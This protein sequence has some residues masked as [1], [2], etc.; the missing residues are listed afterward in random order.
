MPISG[1]EYLVGHRQETRSGPRHEYF[2]IFDDLAIG[3][4]DGDN[5]R[6]GKEAHGGGHPRGSLVGTPAA[7]AHATVRWLL[8]RANS[9]L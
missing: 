8:E 2:L 3:I 5:G 6:L 9:A 4:D 7:L 1:T